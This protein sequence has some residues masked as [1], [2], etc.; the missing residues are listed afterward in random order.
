M[1]NLNCNLVDFY[2]Q[3]PSSPHANEPVRRFS[4]YGNLWENRRSNCVGD[5]THLKNKRNYH[6]KI[7]G[8]RGSLIFVIARHQVIL[9]SDKAT[10]PTYCLLIMTFIW[11]EFLSLLFFLPRY[12]PLII[13][14]ETKMKYCQKGERKKWW[15]IILIKVKCFF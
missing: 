9:S 15:E 10:F 7:C 5:K 12:S 4:I 1:Y 3:E 11:G 2:Y 6:A 13:V 8:K 14:S